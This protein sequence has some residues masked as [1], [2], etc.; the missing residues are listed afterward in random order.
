MRLMRGETKHDQ[1]SVC[2]VDAVPCVSVVAL[3]GALG[4]NKVEDFVLTLSRHKGVRKYH[5]KA[6]P[7]W[8]S[9]APLEDVRL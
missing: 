2:S 4:A 7:L 5:S 8:I 9:V 6:S 3:L 1:V